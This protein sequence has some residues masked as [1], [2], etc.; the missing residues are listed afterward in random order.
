MKCPCHSGKSYQECCSLY[1][2]GFKLPESSEK[3]MRSRYSAYAL[4]LSNYI[5][6]TTHPANPAYE[7]NRD[8]WKKGIEEF[9]KNITFAGLTIEATEDKNN[10]GTVTFYARLL[11]SGKDVSFREK[12]QFEKVNGKWLY[13]SGQM[14]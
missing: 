10:E 4:G 3:L 6:A 12:S 7:Q 2:E 9:S 5:I 1:H 13:K 8:T 11:E 14:Y